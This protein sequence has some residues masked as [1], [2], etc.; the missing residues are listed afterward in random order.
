MSIGLILITTACYL[1]VAVSEGT[2]GNWAMTTVFIGYALANFGLI[3][4]I[5]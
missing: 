3:A 2:K 4:A 5:Y 1:G